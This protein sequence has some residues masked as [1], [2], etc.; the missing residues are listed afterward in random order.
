M[1][2]VTAAIIVDIALTFVTPALAFSTDSTCQ[3]IRIG[4]RTLRESW[5]LDATYVLNRRA[6]QPE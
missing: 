2:R 3:A 1:S 4:L 5:A 6:P